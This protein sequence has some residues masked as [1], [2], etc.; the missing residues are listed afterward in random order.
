[1]KTFLIVLVIVVLVAIL[2]VVLAFAKK[3]RSKT[4]LGVPPD[5]KSLKKNHKNKITDYLTTPNGISKYTGR[6][7]ID[8]MTPDKKRIMLNG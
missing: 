1:M 7:S 3:P 6:G 4:Y 5:L 2:A 8:P